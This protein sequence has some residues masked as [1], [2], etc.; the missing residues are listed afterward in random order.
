MQWK[1][2]AIFS[3]GGRRQGSVKMGAGQASVAEVMSSL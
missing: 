1:N 2:A 3:P